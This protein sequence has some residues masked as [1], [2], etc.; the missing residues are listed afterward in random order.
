MK[1]LT[2]LK[3]KIQHFLTSGPFLGLLCGFTAVAA[4]PPYYHAVFFFVAFSG[5]MILLNRTESKRQAAVLGFCFGFG[6][7]SAGLAWVSNAL[8]IDG[9]GFQTLAPFP[10]LGFGLWGG[11]FPA[12][13]CLAAFCVPKGLRRVIAFSAAWG[14]LEW[15]RSWLFTGF[16]WNLIASIWTDYPAMIQSASVWGAYGL[17]MI[18]V[19][20]AGL[21]SL[22]VGL[23]KE[24]KYTRAVIPFLC[25]AAVI[26]G[27]YG[28]GVLRLKRAPAVSETIRGTMIRLV[29][30]NIPQGKKWSDDDAERN[31]M[32]H[33]HLSRAKGAEQVTHVVWPETATQFL[34][35]NNDF[36]R[37]MVTSALLPG[38][39]LMAGSLRADPVEGAFPPFKMYNSIVVL[40]D[41]GVY[42][43]SYDKS[44]LVPFGEYAPL[45]SVFPFIRKLTPVGFDFSVGGGVRTV[46][47][48]RTLP[49]GMLVCYEVIFPGQVADN[50][51]R[52]YW[53]LNVTNDGW[54]GIS[55]GPHQHFAAAQMR[56]VEEGLPLARAANTGISGMI[57]AYGRVT[58]VLE[59]GKKGV[60]DA[61]LPR[62][63]EKT[64]FYGK[65]GNRIPLAMAV[66]FLLLSFLPLKKKK[67]EP[68]ND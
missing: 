64:T 56:A 30:A 59:L 55:A 47:L 49:V 14:I 18:S 57:D 17:G 53:L 24:K 22:G 33:V 42:L 6:Y 38:S 48:P 51:V 58:A 54:Y 45:S 39:I 9:M 12:A 40:N 44:H 63:T 61:G 41:I 15:V 29:Q 36:A 4:L 37:S 60:V 26:G 13:A 65:Y 5:L 25:A 27:L 68:P 66:F 10:P 62:R 67:T 23:L 28:F 2:I 34:L 7:F 31:L 21:L 35:L 16:P 20:A 19:F 46:T 43:G 50:Q 1:I 3:N 32:T 11:L 52:P 8:M